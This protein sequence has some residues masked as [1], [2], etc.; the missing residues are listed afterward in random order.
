MA[1]QVIEHE[2]TTTAA[3]ATVFALLADGSTWPSWSPIGSFEIE[4]PGDGR[5]EGVGALRRFRTGRHVSRERVVAVEPN[6]TFSYVLVSGLA[7]RDYR[8][9]VSLRPHG[10]GTTISWRSTF[11][12]KVPGNGWIYRRQ[13]DRFIG[14]TVHGLAAAAADVPVNR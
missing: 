5:P 13:L 9:V 11:R 7:I 8:A 3:P 6:E 1:Q 14:Q 2:V 12:P 10:S 4:E